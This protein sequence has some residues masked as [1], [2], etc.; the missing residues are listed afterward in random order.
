MKRIRERGKEGRE[1]ERKGG[2]RE[3][4]VKAYS[5]ILYQ[6]ANQSKSVIYGTFAL[7]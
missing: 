5:D 1:K 3:R 4:G 7:E 6:N 2:G